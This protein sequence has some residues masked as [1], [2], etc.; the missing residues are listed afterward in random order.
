MARPRHWEHGRGVVDILTPLAADLRAVQC[1]EITMAEYR[2]RFLDARGRWG[3]EMTPA[4]L[5]AFPDPDD[6]ESMKVPVGDGDTLCCAC[7]R[8]RA[9]RGE[10]HRVWAAELLRD[11]GWRVV[12]DGVE[13]NERQ[14]EERC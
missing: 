1:G 5:V 14:G 3:H 8:K 7:S 2:R 13:L 10:C 4:E 9:S 12:L 11:A 6:V